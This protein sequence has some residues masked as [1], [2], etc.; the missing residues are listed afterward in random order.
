MTSITRAITE[1][2]T[3]IHFGWMSNVG[4]R[5]RMAPFNGIEPPQVCFFYNC[6]ALGKKA[7][8]SAPILSLNIFYC[9]LRRV[10]HEFVEF[11]KRF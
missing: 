3:K 2:R 10:T 7:I 8:T 9:Y 5:R 4:F 6:N 11:T 1:R